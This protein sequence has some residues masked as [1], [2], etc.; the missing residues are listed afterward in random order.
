METWTL[1][2]ED[3]D[4]SEEKL[5]EALMTLGNGFF[6][7]RGAFLDSE[8]DEIHYPGTYLAGGYNRTTSKILGQEI[9]NEDL[10]NWPNWLPINFSSVSGKWFKIEDTQILNYFIELDM[11]NGELKRFIYFRDEA[12]RESKLHISYFVSMANKHVGAIQWSLMPLN[13]SGQIKIRT[14][15]D[16]NVSNAGVERYRSLNHH[17]LT[18]TNKSWPSENSFLIE[19]KTSFSQLNLCQAFSVQLFENEKKLDCVHSKFI[20]DEKCGLEYSLEVSSGMNLTLEKK[21]TLF[22]SR[23]HAIGQPAYESIRLLQRLPP[24]TSLLNQHK[25]QW[26]RLWNLCDIELKGKVRENRLLRLHIF[27]LLQTV[28]FNSIDLDVGVPARGLHGEAYRGHIFW[29]EIFILP[30]LNLRVPQISRSL[31]L[32]RYRRLDE[33]RVNALSK[34]F[35]G[36]MFPWQSG[37][38][39]EE[40]GQTI[41]V[42][43]VS[44]HWVPD[45]SHLQRHI[46]GSIIY[47]IWK[48]FQATDDKEFLSMYGVEIAL[49]ISR[50][51]VS[52][53]VFNKNRERYEIHS[54][55]GPDEFHTHYPGSADEGINNNAYTNYIASWSIRTSIELLLTLDDVRQKQI[56][57]SLELSTQELERWQEMSRKI[58]LPLRDDGILEQFEGFNDLLDL[59]WNAYKKKY[60]NIQRMDRILEAEGDSVNRYK[61]NKQSD[62]LMLYY[63]FNA[64]ELSDGYGWMGYPFSKD[65]I[66]NNIDYHLSLSTNGSSLSR[67]VHAWVLS[68]YDKEKSWE[69]FCRALET[70]V[71]DIQSGTS[72]EGIHLGAMA[73]TVDLV[74]RC[75]SGIEVSQDVLWISP[76]L[77]SQLTNIKFLLNFRNNTLLLKITDGL[78]HL[79]VLQSSGLGKLGI[80]AKIYQFKQGD[81]F[82]SI[83]DAAGE[84]PGPFPGDFH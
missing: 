82:H 44:E 17:H 25:V 48:Y 80:G 2:F 77:P 11:K 28:S 16:G 42:N 62:V 7:T 59:D 83:Q 3:Y 24:Y 30:F 53:L 58:Y 10:V 47:N 4:P 79:K 22:S 54:V 34:G 76:N 36:A 29:D 49:E 73:G 12:G 66:R 63:L 74:Q 8:A 81:E 45:S 71:A 52:L 15:V 1:K 35:K 41:H 43:P 31:L 60:G 37:S 21:M 72:A 67:I 61:V 20:Q 26:D 70:D 27:H 78:V 57:R 13:W 5:R 32:Y 6:S 39:G 46:N 68:R 14:W 65:W 56:I 40:E 19:S 51:W 38:N 84:M 55:V 64:E 75:F 69:W 18:I 33:A 9:E 23:D 50:F